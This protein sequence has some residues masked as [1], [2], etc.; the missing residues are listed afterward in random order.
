MSGIILPKTWNVNCVIFKLALLCKNGMRINATIASMAMKVYIITS[1]LQPVLSN[2]YAIPKYAIL[3]VHQ[4]G[5]FLDI[6]H[7]LVGRV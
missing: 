4:Y 5:V 1:M 7:G 2:T 6:A 3:G